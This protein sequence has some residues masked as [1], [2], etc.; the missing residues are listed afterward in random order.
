MKKAFQQIINVTMALLLLISTTSW[1]IEKHYCMGRLVEVSLFKDAD[2]CGM[3]MTQVAAENKSCC[4][5][6]IIVI[7]GQDDLQFSYDD[8]IIKQQFF[9]V[10]F[11]TSYLNVLNT[12]EEQCIAYDFYLPPILVKDIHTLDQVFLI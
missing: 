4:S 9:I 2:K 11:V 6:E 7:E 3:N 12:L 8:I 1:K 5:D 10:A